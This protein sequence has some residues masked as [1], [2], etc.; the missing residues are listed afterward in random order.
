MEIKKIKLGPLRTNCYVLI[1]DNEALVIDPADEGNIIEEA[2]GNNKLVGLVITHHHFDHVGAV[3]E[4]LDNH[5]IKVY[6]YSNL[7]KENKLGN[8][9]FKVIK[10]PGHSD[11]S[12][13]I[14]FKKERIMFTGDFVFKNTVG[15][16]DIDTGNID[17]M[18]QSINE[19]KK[20]DDVTIHPGHGD[21]TTLD[22]EKKNNYFFQ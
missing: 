2:I 16:T 1:E 20:Y 12:I 4:L 8:F 19:I 7:K 21:S 17:K 22:Y 3:D 6:D 14:Y 15:R 13:T 9:F 11:D 18:K 10:T 5:D